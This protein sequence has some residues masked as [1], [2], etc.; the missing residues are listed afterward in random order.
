M[1]GN[2]PGDGAGAGGI[3]QY[4]LQPSW[5]TG[6]VNGTST[7]FRT[8]PDVSL[9]ADPITGVAVYDTLSAGGFLQVGGTSLAS[10]LMSGILAIANQVRVSNGLQTLDSTPQTQTLPMLYSVP[11]DSYFHDI[12]TGIS[13]N[14]DQFGD[15]EGNGFAASPGYDIASGL[16]SPIANNLINYLGGNS[17]SPP[18]TVSAPADAT[19]LE[20][21]IFNWDDVIS[22]NDA[23]LPG[24]TQQVTL[25]ADEGTIQLSLTNNVS[26]SA[27]ANNSSS[28]TISGT[29]ANLN[30]VLGNVMYLAPNGYVGS[31]Y[32]QISV[33]DGTDSNTGSGVIDMTI[34]PTSGRTDFR[35]IARQHARKPSVQL[36]TGYIAD[37]SGR[38]R[39]LGIALVDGRQRHAHAGLDNRPDLHRRLE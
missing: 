18:P 33:N 36:W 34:V 13:N 8:T 23:Q 31:D 10:P 5:Q 15:N 4:E 30:T 29:L 26:I 11:Q 20:G 39:R 17:T 21:G 9:D 1:W 14:V 3:S 12:T 19:M 37:R 27:G 6:K 16:G 32:I 22:V 28:M 38:Q 35:G 7:E 2:E 25:T 24:T